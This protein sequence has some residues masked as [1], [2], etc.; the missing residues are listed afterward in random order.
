M[1]PAMALAGPA[2]GR[3]PRQGSFGQEP[4]AANPSASVIVAVFIDPSSSPSHL[5]L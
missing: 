4:T 1:R 5:K 3:D 2:R